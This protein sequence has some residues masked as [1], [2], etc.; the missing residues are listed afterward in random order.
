MTRWL[1]LLSSWSNHILDNFAG[2]KSMFGGLPPPKSFNI[3]LKLV[4]I[5]NETTLF[6]CFTILLMLSMCVIPFLTDLCV[7]ILKKSTNLET[8]SFCDRTRKWGRCGI[9][10]QASHSHIWKNILI[11]DYDVFCWFMT[12]VWT[13]KL[14][15]N[16]KSWRRHK[17]H[18]KLSKLCFLN[19]TLRYKMRGEMLLSILSAVD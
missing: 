18:M 14:G 7:R 10:G 5:P 13:E 8:F 12:L 11:D 19:Q 17:I 3:S 9:S 1:G 2:T 4:R 6:T 16:F 15:T